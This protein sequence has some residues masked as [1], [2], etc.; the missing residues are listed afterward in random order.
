[1]EFV[2][3]VPE[4]WSAATALAASFAAGAMLIL[5]LGGFVTLPQ[6][7][8]AIDERLHNVENVIDH[9]DILVCIIS[10]E[11]LD[12]PVEDCVS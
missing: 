12:R 7:V 6:K 2:K 1:M 10:N 8:E 9:L 5:I 3:K 11:R 4:W